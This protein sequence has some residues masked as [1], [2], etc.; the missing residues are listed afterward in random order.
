MS[1]PNLTRLTN[2]STLG[3]HAEE[4]RGLFARENIV[5]NNVLDGGWLQRD[6]RRALRGRN[7]NFP[8]DV[9]AYV[10]VFQRALDNVVDE[11]I[12]EEV[13]TMLRWRH[14]GTALILASRLGLNTVVRSLLDRGADVE[15][16]DDRGATALMLASRGGHKPHTAVVRML[17]AAGAKVDVSDDGPRVVRGFDF[18]YAPGGLDEAGGVPSALIHACS[19]GHAEIVRLL[20]D[21]GAN[22]EKTDIDGVTPLMFA[23]AVAGAHILIPDEWRRYEANV[24][25]LLERGAD[26]HRRDNEGRTAWQ[27]AIKLWNHASTHG[28]PLDAVEKCAEIVE[29]LEEYGAT[30]TRC[31]FGGF[32][33]CAISSTLPCAPIGVIID[34]QDLEKSAAWWRT[35]EFALR[36]LFLGGGANV[37]AFRRRKYSKCHVMIA[38]DHNGVDIRGDWDKAEFWAKVRDFRPGAIVVDN[39]SESWFSP[40]S[41]EQLGAVVRELNAMLLISLNTAL[42]TSEGYGWLSLVS[43]RYNAMRYDKDAVLFV[44]WSGLP[45]REQWASEVVVQVTTPW[46]ARDD[47]P[48]PERRKQY[49]ALE[50]FGPEHLDS[51]DD[52]VAAQLALFSTCA[53]SR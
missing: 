16:K 14:G 42:I 40:F 5:V 21:A 2:K 4:S 38:G 47:I 45:E 25:T 41:V 13:G 24:R 17:I 23:V 7:N 6:V 9:R 46:G 50:A 49:E 15:A 26:V 51:F 52:A 10:E 3:S 37:D 39:G 44:F 33:R 12:E 20:L 34:Q 32:D 30:R 22:I 11:R 8:D 48:A 28:H 43:R 35:D 29:L 36:L 53:S 31:L 27:Y 18:D 19:N 1:L